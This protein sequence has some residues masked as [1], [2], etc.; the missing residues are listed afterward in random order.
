M[1]FVEYDWRDYSLLKRNKERKQLQVSLL[2]G[3]GLCEGKDR[4]EFCLV[5]T[6]FME[7]MEDELVLDEATKVVIKSILADRP[8]GEPYKDNP[9]IM[10]QQKAE[11]W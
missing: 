1:N 3:T 4:T 2:E 6:K 10:S 5:P 7:K 8:D 9:N 11:V